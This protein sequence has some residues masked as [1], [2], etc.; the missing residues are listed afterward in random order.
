MPFLTKPWAGNIVNMALGRSPMMET[1]AN[2]SS[3]G[4]R[5]W[6]S[7]GKATVPAMRPDHIL[8]SKEM[9]PNHI[10]ELTRLH[11]WGRTTGRKRG[12]ENLQTLEIKSHGG[13]DLATRLNTGDIPQTSSRVGVSHSRP[14]NAYGGT[15]AL[16]VDIAN[17][18]TAMILTENGCGGRRR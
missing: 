14:P 8:S 3:S 18:D 12:S 1:H 15:T 7:S 5:R 17:D 10:V 16:I 9:R 2:G 4:S 13:R 6:S 11:V